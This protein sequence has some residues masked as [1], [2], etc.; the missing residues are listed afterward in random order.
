LSLSSLSSAAAAAAFRAIWG[1]TSQKTTILTLLGN[2]R[3]YKWFIVWCYVAVQYTV[4]SLP[5]VSLYN[6]F[7]QV[8]YIF[9]WS[10]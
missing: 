5:I 8:F 7:L 2:L 6:I 1:V 9:F 10:L 4:K 3:S